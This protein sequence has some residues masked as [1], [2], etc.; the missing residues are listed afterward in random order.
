MPKAR[1]DHF[2]EFAEHTRLKHLVLGAYLESW[3]R[4]LLIGGKRGGRVWF[5]DGFAGAGQ[6]RHGNPGSPLIAARVAQNLL[7]EMGGVRGGAPM[8]VLA[9]EKDSRRHEQLESVLEPHRSSKPPVARTTAGELEDYLGAIVERAGNDPVLY[10]LDPFGVKG[11]V[12]EQLP[13]LLAGPQNEV[14]VLFSHMGARRLHAAMLSEGRDLETDV[15]QI[16]AA[17]SLFPEF[18]QEAIEAVRKKGRRSRESLQATQRSAEEI[19]GAALGPDAIEQASSVPPEDR[20][21]ILTRI[22]MDRLREAGAR[23]VVALPVRNAANAPIYQLVYATKSPVGLRTMKE[24]MHTGLNRSDL[25]DQARAAIRNELERPIQQVVDELLQEFSGRSVPW[26]GGVK[27]YLLE[28]TLVFPWQFDV[29]KAELAKYR[30]P[31][32][33]IVYNIPL[34]E[35]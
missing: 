14:F 6:D 25:P 12:V 28:E 15:E 11:L 20:P 23:Y 29:I 31:G 26:V 17:P 7:G 35:S 8:V 3:A 18:D 13:T 34:K 27:Q 19:L 5:V 9:I 24:A 16:R 10:F 21:A 4:K 1:Q 22:F 30:Q 32:G 33:T 2:E